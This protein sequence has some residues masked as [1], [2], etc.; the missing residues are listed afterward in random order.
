[1]SPRGQAIADVREQL[2]QAAERLLLRNDPAAL[3]GRAVTRE[4]GLAVGL[5]H[6]HFGDF[7]TFLADFVL[8]RLRQSAASFASLSLHAG[9]GTVA[10][11][12]TEATV[13]LLGPDTLAL[14]RLV[15]ARPSV[16]ARSVQA[17][18]ATAHPRSMLEQAVVGYLQQEQRRGRIEP[19]A[20]I[21]SAAFALVATVHQLLLM[22]TRD[23]QH[24]RALLR[25]VIAL[26]VS[27]I[28]AD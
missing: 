9:E 19:E 3:S 27:G 25:R 10:A 24:T 11:N 16:L 6:N 26:L 5:L 20:D 28:V 13:S 2:F 21:E 17:H 15:G 18:T 1:M 8:A 22:P 7:D 12:L 4:A 23:E 14:S